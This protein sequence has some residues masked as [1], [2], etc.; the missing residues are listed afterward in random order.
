MD[1]MWETQSYLIIRK[2]FIDSKTFFW[3]EWLTKGIN[4]NI[5]KGVTPLL[6]ENGQV[7]SFPVFQCK[8]PLQKT[9]FL[10]YYQ[11]IAA[12]PSRLLRKETT[13]TRNP[14][15]LLKI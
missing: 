8:Y 3:K 7:L 9:T 14:S 6:D 4:N 12:I 13:R 10:H 15:V 2:N 5:A 1:V 11:V